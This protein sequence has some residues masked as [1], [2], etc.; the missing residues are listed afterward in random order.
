MDSSRNR[1]L[2][3]SATKLFQLALLWLCCVLTPA[4]TIAQPLPTQLGDLDTDG[5]VTVL[6]LVRLINH[7]QSSAGV[8]PANS[9]A[10][11]QPASSTGILPVELRGYADVTG[12]GTIDQRDI[13]MLA[14]AILGIP[15]PTRPRPIISEP[16]SG[17]SEVGVTVRPRV[18]FPKPIIPATL[19]SNN[20]Y[21]SFAGVLFLQARLTNSEE[22]KL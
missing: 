5:Q 18:Y 4:R 14:D 12:D 22:Q 13:D 10:G 9:G 17:A 6:D 19:N 15:I 20:F 21:A 8:S 7:I 16:A 11:F 2:R 3:G 1:G